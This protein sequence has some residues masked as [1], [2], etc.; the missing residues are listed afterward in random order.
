M[1][2]T[3]KDAALSATNVTLLQQVEFKV[4]GT[5]YVEVLVDDVMKLRYPIAVIH[6]PQPQQGGQPQP[7]AQ[8]KPAD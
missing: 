6:A 4:A 2:F 3:L 1:K 7:P 8:D 5:Y